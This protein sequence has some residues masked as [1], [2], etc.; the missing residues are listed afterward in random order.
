MPLETISFFLLFIGTKIEGVNQIDVMIFRV[1][2]WWR[3]NFID[4]M[5]LG[6]HI[7]LEYYLRG[8][9]IQTELL[10]NQS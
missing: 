3:T 9:K 8:E 5:R 7:L 1:R 2:I 4:E 6:R 10:R